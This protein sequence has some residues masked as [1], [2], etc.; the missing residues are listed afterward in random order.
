MSLHPY[1]ECDLCR[2][3]W[4]CIPT[5]A[6][7]DISVFPSLGKQ[8]PRFAQDQP[9]GYF[10]L[11]ELH[12]TTKAYSQMNAGW[13]VEKAQYAEFNV[14]RCGEIAVWQLCRERQPLW[15]SHDGPELNMLGS[16]PRCSFPWQKLLRANELLY[17]SLKNRWVYSKHPCF[18]RRWFLQVCLGKLSHRSTPL[19]TSVLFCGC[20]SNDMQRPS[21]V[22][23]QPEE[24]LLVVRNILKWML[25]EERRRPSM[26]SSMC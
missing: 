3:V 21:F 22:Q 1:R 10:Q 26:L 23:G 20:A 15:N 6:F 12:K 7:V 14:P 24:Q 13:K 18:R 4:E 5:E 9:K 16:M 17:S 25:I 11:K 8:Q 19:W 2:F